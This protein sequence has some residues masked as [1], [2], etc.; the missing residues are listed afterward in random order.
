M[1]TF[2]GESYLQEQLDSLYQQTHSDWSI[3]SSDDGS[4][5]R[6]LEILRQNQLSLGSERL[7]IRNGPARG[8]SSNFLSLLRAGDIDAQ[9]FAFCDQDDLWNPDK[10]ENALNWLSSVPQNVPALF[11]SRTRLINESGYPMG[12]SPLFRRPPSFSNAL[13]QSIAGG[14]TMVMNVAARNLMA[15]TPQ[16]MSVASHDWW[17]YLLVTGCGG[18]VFYE[19][20]PQV[21]YRQHGQNLMGSNT[22]LRDRIARLIKMFD[23]TFRDWNSANITALE[24][25]EQ[26]LTA[27]NRTSLDVFRHARGGSLG[28]RL[29]GLR[30]A[31]IHRQSMVENLGLTAAILIN[32][33]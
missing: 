15:R 14:N 7:S 9:Y 32:R 18:A 25:F 10:L 31:G 19:S 29:A 11:C 21:D 33:V 28:C 23:G 12:F 20:T 8:F 30:R 1:S 5:D 27:L 24:S 6:T 22:R 4:S 17:A 26:E 13:V 2:N 3:Y 16:D